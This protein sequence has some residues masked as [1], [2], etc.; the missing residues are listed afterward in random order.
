MAISALAITQHSDLPETHMLIGLKQ[1]GVN[2]DVMC[3][4]SAP[5]L[6]LLRAAGINVIHLKLKSRFDKQGTQAIRQQLINH[7]YDIMHVFNNKAT[8]NGLRA[9]RGVSLKIIAYRGIVGNVSFL[10]PMS[11]TTY[12][13]PRVD[14]IVCVAEAIRQYLLNMHFFGLRIAPQK[15]LTIHKGHSLSWYQKQPADLTQFGITKGDFVVGCTAA[16]R[17]RKGIEFLIEAT[18]Y[19]P[20]DANIHLVLVGDMHKPE[21]LKQIE[22]SHYKN[23]I[24]LLG[25]RTD[26][27]QIMSACNACILPS[28][29]REGLPKSIIEGMVYAIAPIV[30]D[31]GGSPELVEDGKSGIIVPPKSSR[32]IAQAIM[33]LY[34]NPQLCKQ[35]GINAQQR[36]DKDFHYKD[37][38][39]KTLELYHQLVA[40]K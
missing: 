24:H 16:Y 30:T 15:L 5:H 34:E 14:R 19:L 38:I 21:L 7:Q 2:I 27:P 12:L 25:Y 37:T 40:E 26:A 23:R 32:A 1:A 33:Q 11:W 39:T 18:Q 17:P 6:S 29:K 8:S 31:S 22:K 35:M 4:D 9:S 36:I 13:H 28:I 3:P 20:A 10:D